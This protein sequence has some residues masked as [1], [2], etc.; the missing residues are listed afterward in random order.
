MDTVK[1]L[2][3]REAWLNGLGITRLGDSNVLWSWMFA[4]ANTLPFT[5]LAAKPLRSISTL[6]LFLGSMFTRKTCIFPKLSSDAEADTACSRWPPHS[7]SLE[8]SWMGTKSASWCTLY[9][10]ITW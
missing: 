2:P 4:E 10:S 8:M 7:K 1:R 3:D 9:I 5:C 6:W